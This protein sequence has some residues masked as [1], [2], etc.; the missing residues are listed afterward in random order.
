MENKIVWITGASSGLGE[1]LA[2]ECAKSKVKLVL[3]AR[4]DAELQ[5]VKTECAKFI[6]AENILTLPLDVTD[7]SRVDAEVEKVIQKFGRI[8]ILINNAGVVQR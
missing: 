4:R 6:S 2:L 7:L 5:R 1:A 3:S 8:D